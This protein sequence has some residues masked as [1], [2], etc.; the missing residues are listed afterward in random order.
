MFPCLS[1]YSSDG[2]FFFFSTFCFPLLFYFF[3]VTKLR[4]YVFLLYLSYLI[5]YV[6]S[7]YYLIFPGTV[8]ISLRCTGLHFE[9][10]F[11]LSEGINEFDALFYFYF[12]QIV[13]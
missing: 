6:Y 9:T 13:R 8:S 2:T 3:T 5:S 4:I 11:L 12:I 10:S 7:L 1:F